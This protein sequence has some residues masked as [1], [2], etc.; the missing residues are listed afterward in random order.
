MQLWRSPASALGLAT[1][2]FV[3]VQLL[4]VDRPDPEA[5]FHVAV[6]K[7]YLS[8]GWMSE[9]PWMHGTWLAHHFVDPYWLTHWLTIPILVVLPNPVQ[10]LKLIEVLAA[11]AT[12]YCLARTLKRLGVASA[13]SW[14]LGAL[15]LTPTA[16]IRI[17]AYRGTTLFT[18]LWLVF[19]VTVTR[20]RPKLIFCFSWVA[21]Y[22]YTGFPLLP[23]TALAF[24]LAVALSESRLEWKPT[25]ASLTG[26][27]AGLLANPFFP[28]HFRFY[29]D[30][31]IDSILQDG[32]IPGITLSSEW[33]SLA[34]FDLVKL[35]TIPLLLTA[36][37]GLMIAAKGRK[38][39]TQ[40]VFV[41][42]LSIGLF[43]LT[44]RSIKFLD[45]AQLTVW[46]AFALSW[47]TVGGDLRWSKWALAILVA[48]IGA[49]NLRATHGYL[50]AVQKGQPA[51]SEFQA[52]G[53]FLR[54][55]TGNHEPV[56]APW[57]DFP[58]LFMTNPHNTY[59]VG[60]N[61]NYLRRTDEKRF[62]AYTYLYAGAFK[63]PNV[64]IAQF[65]DAKMLVTRRNP[66]NR[67]EQQLLASLAEYPLMRK[68]YEND[69]F[70]VYRNL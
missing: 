60:L 1:L 63:D 33:A 30:D 14:A 20:A 15:A 24:A 65:F 48:A 69:S 64:A 55:N 67:G 13:Y 39:S 46:I 68:A 58:L 5:V 17:G 19:L 8:S 59:P 45:Y 44:A 40:A 6:A 43:L 12:V 49:M 31:F 53:D 37:T 47:P 32:L 11:T 52:L 56:V 57:E 34:G 28:R 35:A 16:V 70:L 27:A 4:R 29:R 51:I 26:V 66:R 62:A 22:L 23:L 54:Q 10:A 42:V 41:W 2:C 25:V 3:V 61:P 50:L 36:F 9:F 7:A 21:V 38:L 18:L